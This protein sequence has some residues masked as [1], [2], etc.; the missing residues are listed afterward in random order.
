LSKGGGV[1][2]PPLELKGQQNR[3]CS[4][5]FDEQK[6]SSAIIDDGS[7]WLNWLVD[8]L[9]RRFGSSRFIADGSPDAHEC[10]TMEHAFANYGPDW[11]FIRDQQKK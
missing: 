11:R 5:I 4:D 3:P 2:R 9:G 8:A 6:N 7:P 1:T 10:R